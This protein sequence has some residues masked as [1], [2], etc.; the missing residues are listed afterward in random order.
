MEYYSQTID[1]VYHELDS[2]PN[3]LTNKEAEERIAKHGRNE[4]VREKEIKPFMIFLSQFTDFIIWILIAAAIVSIVLGI[5]SGKME[6]WID[7]IVIIIILVLNAFLGFVKEYRA[8]KSIE[9]LKKMTS[10]KAVARRDGAEQKIDATLLVPGDIISLEVGEKVPADARLIEATVL[11]C[12]EAALTGESLPVD[13]K[14]GVVKQG[15]AVADRSNMVFNGTIITRGHGR[16]IVVSTGMSSEIGKIAGM[17]QK[18]ESPKTPLQMKLAHFGKVLGG[19]VLAVCV[20]IFLAGIFRGYDVLTMFLAAVSLAVAAVPEGLP[21]VV[22]ITLSLGVQK[23]VKRN[24][25]IRKL[26]SVETLGCTTVICSDKT[27]TLT[28][29]QMT[30]TKVYCDSQVIEVSGEG[31]STKGHFAKQTEDLKQL[32][33]IGVLCNDAKLREKE[34]IGDPTEAALLVSAAKLGLRKEEMDKLNPRADEIPFDSERKMMT[35]INKVNNSKYAFTKGAPDVIL[36][37]CNRILEN[38]KVRIITKKDKDNILAANEQFAREALR[39]LGFACKEI[40]YEKVSEESLIFVGLQAMIDPPRKEAIS[41]VALCRKAGI[42][43]VMITGDH[44]V[45]AQAVAKQLGIMGRAITGEELDK[46]SDEEFARDVEKISIFARVNPAHKTKIVKALEKHGHVTAMTGDGVN[47][48]P[49]LKRADI[50]VAMGI[51]GTDVAK[52]ASDMILL[53]DNFSSLVAAVEEGRTIFDNIQ[54]FVE[55]LLSCNMGEVL[56]IFSAILAGLKLPLLPLQILWMNLVTDGLPAL[57]LGV[58]PEEPGVMD[59]LPR[60]KGNKIV[61]RNGF[62]RMFIL[63]AIM[64]AGTLVVFISFYDNLEHAQTMAFTTLVMFQLFQVLNTRSLTKSLFTVGVFKNRWLWA[65]IGSSLLLQ[66]MVIYSPLNKIFHCV[67]LSVYDWGFVI[68]ISLSV[69]VIREVWKLFS[70]H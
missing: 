56:V 27:G 60:E 1:D 33:K 37:K 8:E 26:P 46:I 11:E 30:V 13:K 17:I 39:V 65:A 15:T 52:E 28:H 24:A 42:R 68:L 44:K 16:A 32:L 62:I 14:A 38:G 55:Y 43:V 57:A 20:F 23:M 35:T 64:A 41:S 25:L 48:A 47:D 22:T 7:A 10:L 63:G 59:R 69:F 40:K 61:S 36:S 54:K 53:D 67:P 5:Y 18:E 49:A 51:S 58:D 66:L 70:K 3:G 29:N 19:V 4:I 12:E 50:G 21:A 2:S 9:A 34:V 6:E 45:T 31:Y